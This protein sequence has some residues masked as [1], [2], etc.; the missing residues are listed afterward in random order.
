MPA[1]SN[2]AAWLQAGAAVFQAVA[3]A[4]TGFWALY[5]YRTSRKGRASLGLQQEP[6]LIPVDQSSGGV[7]VFHLRI[8]NLSGVLFRHESSIAYLMDASQ[9]ARDGRLVLLPFAA[10]DPLLPVLGGLSSDPSE[11][12]AGRLFT[13]E[14]RGEVSLEPGEAVETSLAFKITDDRLLALLVSIQGYEQIKR[15]PWKAKPWVWTSFAYVDPNSVRVGSRS[16]G[17]QEVENAGSS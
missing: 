3:L 17:G 15:W 5:L 6:R 4:I 13:Y 10:Q 12:R 9:V 11:V 16:L 14:Q 2:G 8:S 7:L 1:E